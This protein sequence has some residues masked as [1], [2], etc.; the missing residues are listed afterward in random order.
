MRLTPTTPPW[1]ELPLQNSPNRSRVTYHTG[2]TIA[3]TTT[4]TPTAPTVH[5]H[6][7]SYHLGGGGGGGLY[8]LAPIGSSSSRMSRVTSRPATAEMFWKKSLNPPFDTCTARA[9]TPTSVVSGA[10]P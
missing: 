6:H 2:T 9:P 8:G 4:P 7:F 10:S 5:T 1:Q 3:V